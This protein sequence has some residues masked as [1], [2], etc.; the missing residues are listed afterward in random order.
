MSTLQF[1]DV[2][3]DTL[4]PN[5]WNTNVVTP[6]NEQKIE[7][8][9]KR[10]GL[11]RPIIVRE[12]G[13]VLEILGGQH[14]WQV[15]KKLAFKTVPVVNLGTID[16]AKAKEI[17]L[18]DNGR[19]GEDDTLALAELLK[20]MGD[21]DEL[22]EFLPYSGDDLESIFASSNISLDDL[23]IPDDDDRLPE[24]PLPKTAQTHQIMRFK[25]PVG[26][27]AFVQKRIEQ[28]MKSQGFSDDDSMMNA[29][30]ALVVLLKGE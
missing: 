13:G 1:A 14:R 6:E 29:G 5:P 22:M 21:A 11:F 30:H 20:E 3:I 17:G 12:K 25:V 27:A 19:Y 28:V 2:D 7:A 4:R 26:D 8:S 23:D 18:V 16:D 24:M 10:F 15:A 9:V